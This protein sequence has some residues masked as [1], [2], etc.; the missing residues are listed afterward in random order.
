MPHT[1]LQNAPIIRPQ[2]ASSPCVLF[3][4]ILLCLLVKLLLR[5]ASTG[6]CA[7]STC[8]VPEW[9]LFLFLFLECLHVTSMSQSAGLI[10]GLMPFPGDLT[11]LLSRL[12]TSWSFQSQ[13][14]LWCRLES[15][16]RSVVGGKKNGKRMMGRS[17]RSDW[18]GVAVG[19]WIKLKKLLDIKRMTEQKRGRRELLHSQSM[20]QRYLN[21][22]SVSAKTERLS[23]SLS[24]LK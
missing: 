19:F 15:N 2:D 3:G 21:F 7:R 13:H 16:H 5:L 20:R 1:T 24:V 10:K 23:Q 6:N 14:L 4:L 9:R 8:C 22:F 12:E 11:E 18:V 17:K